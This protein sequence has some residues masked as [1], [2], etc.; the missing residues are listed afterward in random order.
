VQLGIGTLMP[1][2]DVFLACHGRIAPQRSKCIK[3]V[4]NDAN[5]SPDLPQQIMSGGIW[6]WG[7]GETLRA[8]IL[9]GASN[10]PEGHNQPPLPVVADKS[11]INGM[12]PQTY[13]SSAARRSLAPVFRKRLVLP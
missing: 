6:S 1:R 7:S 10:T 11:E 13:P 3:L 5:A 9:A 12:P 4:M 2:Q 8:A